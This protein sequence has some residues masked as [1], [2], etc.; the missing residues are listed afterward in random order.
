MQEEAEPH[1][2]PSESVDRIRTQ[3]KLDVPLSPKSQSSR[4]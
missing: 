3:R 2:S 1:G 4:S